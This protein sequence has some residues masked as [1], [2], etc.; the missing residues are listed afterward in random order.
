M[1]IVNY[2]IDNKK[3]IILGIVILILITFI[4][5]SKIETFN[6]QT[7]RFCTTCSGKNFNQCMNCFNCGFCV[8]KS[9]NG[10][11]I[12]GDNRS[13]PYN[14]ERC[15]RWIDSGVY[16]HQHNKYNK[17]DKYKEKTEEPTYSFLKHSNEDFVCNAKD[18]SGPYGAG[19]CYLW[20]HTDPYTYML[21]RNA[22]YKCSHGPRSSN[23]IIGI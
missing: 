2:I 15:S 6:D 21:Q 5:G 9:G 7:G 4:S 14:Y 1:N 3:Y 23:R 8:D 19:G 17:C 18:A 11:C 10:Q 20:Y 12:G 16:S 22:N 13:G